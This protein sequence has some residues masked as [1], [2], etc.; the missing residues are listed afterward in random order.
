MN[1]PPGISDPSRLSII[2]PS[3]HFH[4]Q[5]HYDM[6]GSPLAEILLVVTWLNNQN[7]NEWNTFPFR[8]HHRVI[9]VQIAL[10]VSTK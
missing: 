10:K 6:S 9:Q 7:M 4:W 2:A 3:W 5:P 1:L 8:I